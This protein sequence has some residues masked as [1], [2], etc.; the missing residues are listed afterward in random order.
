MEGQNDCSSSAGR[1][2]PIGSSFPSPLQ[3]N[4]EK[5]HL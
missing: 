2:Q 3:K 4:L 1:R 5:V